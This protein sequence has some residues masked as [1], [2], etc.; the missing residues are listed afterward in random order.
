MN[1]TST[2][3]VSPARRVV[4]TIYGVVQ[5]VGFRPFV[6]NTARRRELIGW[7]RNEAGMVRIEVQG[8]GPAVEAFLGDLRDR[9][10]PQARIDSIEVEETLP[11][12]FG[13]GAGGEGLLRA[14]KPSP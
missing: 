8:D 6:Y 9:H 13:R 7:V 14:A 2:P 4:I 10:P 12:P 3:L 5:G 11:S 1:R